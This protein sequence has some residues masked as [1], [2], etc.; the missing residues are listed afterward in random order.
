MTV[1]DLVGFTSYF[2]SVTLKYIL[3]FPQVVSN[4]PSLALPF[5]QEWKILLLGVSSENVR[6]PENTIKLINFRISLKQWFLGGHLSKDAT[7]RPNVNRAR[8]PLCAQH[9]FWGTVP[10]SH[11]LKHETYIF[12]NQ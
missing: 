12:Y 5:P 10:Q 3:I 11:N 1:S 7:N 2:P 8:V 4:F 9:Q 6:S